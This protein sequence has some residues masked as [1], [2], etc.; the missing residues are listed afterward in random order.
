MQDDTRPSFLRPKQVASRLGVSIATV[1]RMAK[2]S[3][4]PSPIKITESI[5]AWRLTDIEE[6]ERQLDAR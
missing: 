4:F 3:D 6:W 1:W 2:R 5:T